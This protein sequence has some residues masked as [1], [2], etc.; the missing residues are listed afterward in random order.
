MKRIK[1]TRGKFAL[2]DDE[3][4]DELIKHKWH[5]KAGRNTFYAARGVRGRNGEPFQMIFIHRELMK[6][7]SDKKV[8]HRDENGLNNQKENLRVCT[9]VQNL[10]NRGKNK[11]NTSGYKGVSRVEA[12]KKWAANI[13]INNK[14]KFLGY[15][16]DISEAARAYNKAAIKHHGEFARLN[17][18]A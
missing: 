1:L 15:F 11:N 9:D 10:M 4:Y 17:K 2:V 18:V 12:R 14:V 8:D 5:A 16:D 6:N 3:D 13:G 7:P